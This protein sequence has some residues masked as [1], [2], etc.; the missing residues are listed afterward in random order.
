M[1]I[2]GLVCPKCNTFIYSRAR[3]DFQSCPCGSI[4]ID[5]GVFNIENETLSFEGV[6]FKESEINP[7]SIEIKE[8]EINIYYREIYNDWKLSKNK[9]GYIKNFKKGDKV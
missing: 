3:H 5:G 2:K 7:S 4:S 6:C 8:T 9:F 1:K